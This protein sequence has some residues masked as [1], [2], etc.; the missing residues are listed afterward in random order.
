MKALILSLLFTVGSCSKEKSIDVTITDST[1]QTD[2]TEA[3]VAEPKKL[4]SE[5][6]L[7]NLNHEILSALKN[8]DYKR[9][10]TFIHPGKGIRFSMYAFVRPDADKRFSRE[11]FAHYISRSTKFTWG[12]KDG[13]GDK[14]VF[15]LTD[16]LENW[17]FKKDF[18]GADFYLNEFKGTG[19]SLN[20]LK[21]RYPGAHFTENYIAGSEKYAFMDWNSLRLV[22]ELYEGDYFLVAVVN[23][24]WTI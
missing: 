4:S 22:F 23:D 12:E 19:N 1:R 15:S 3:A 20:N 18:T 21:E 13:S 14:L 8:K 7:R 9:F 11:D 6:R 17:V 10:S 24:E 16:Y 5:E 2:S